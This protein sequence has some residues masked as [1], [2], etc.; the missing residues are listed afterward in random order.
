VTIEEQERFDEAEDACE[1]AK[2]L[3]PN[4]NESP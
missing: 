3:K 1:E 2:R 4:I